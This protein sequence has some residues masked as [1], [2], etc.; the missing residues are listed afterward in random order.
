MF[1]CS[2]L[3]FP[4]LFNLPF[5]GE[6]ATPIVLASQGFLTLEAGI[7][8]E[9]WE[10]ITPPLDIT[11]GYDAGAFLKVVATDFGFLANGGAADGIWT[12][13][14]G[15]VWTQVGHPSDPVGLGHPINDFLGLA[16]NGDRIAA[17]V[18]DG[19]SLSHGIDPRYGIVTSTDA[20]TWTYTLLVEAAVVEGGD[21]D[22]TYPRGI[23]PYGDDGFIVAGTAIWISTDG[24]E[25]RLVHEG[26][27]QDFDPNDAERDPYPPR[28]EFTAIATDGRKAVL[29]GTGTAALLVTNDGETW[30][31]IPRLV[32]LDSEGQACLPLSPGPLAHGPAGFVTVGSC[33][34]F[35]TVWTSPDGFT[36]TQIPYDESSFG[37]PAGINSIAANERGYVVGGRSGPDGAL[38][39]ATVWTSPD[40]IRWTRIVLE[41][42]EAE[43]GVLGIAI[44]DDAVAAVGWHGDDAA[45]WRSVLTN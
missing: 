10:L 15:V 5:G 20:E 38:Q 43:S 1:L 14:D 45:V 21:R 29:G 18:S 24:E 26:I 32:G 36:W 3:L 17:L 7:A 16:V 13:P 28:L 44:Y 9:G 34:P 31:L 6:C 4:C 41:T 23:A 25:F 8:L 42:T 2:D 19:F 35:E 37:N 22:P 12:S 40:G 11:G 27:L 39:V 30:E 33:G